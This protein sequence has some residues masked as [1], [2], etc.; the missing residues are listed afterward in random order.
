MIQPSGLEPHELEM[1]RIVTVKTI[2]GAVS[3]QLKLAQTQLAGANRF[4]VWLGAGFGTGIFPGPSLHKLSSRAGCKAQAHC[5]A[6]EGSPLDRSHE[7]MFLA[8]AHR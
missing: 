8:R 4:D 5:F 1:K 3:F 6:L 2:D 7:R